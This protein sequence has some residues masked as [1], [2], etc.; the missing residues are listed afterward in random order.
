MTA[1]AVELARERER[2]CLEVLLDL[3]D[4]E[5]VV[6]GGF[7]LSAYGPPRFSV[8]LDLVV[9]SAGAAQISERLNRRG[10]VFDRR[11]H[12]GQAFV[13]ASE[14][15]KSGPLSVDLLIDGVNDRRSGATFAWTEVRRTATR[16]P[17]RGLASDISVTP[18]VAAREVLLAMKLVAG[19]FVDLRD[20]AVLSSG[21]L[22]EEELARLLANCPEGHVRANAVRLASSLDNQNFRDSLKGVY[23]MDDR[24]FNRYVVSTRALCRRLVDRLG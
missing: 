20:V 17:V 23:R 21:P 3:Q 12:G 14:H 7:A 11:W 4:L 13:G 10:Y 5:A 6:V 15:W 1:K 8:D 24:A 2:G 16:R 9:P 19:R 22:D 18:L